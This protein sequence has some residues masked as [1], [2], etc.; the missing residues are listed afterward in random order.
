MKTSSV[1]LLLVT[2][3]LLVVPALAQDEMTDPGAKPAGGAR[4]KKNHQELIKLYDRNGDGRLDDEEKAAAHK[5][6]RKEGGGENDRRKQMLKRFDRD[7][8]GR[9]NDAERAEA[10]KARE[11]IEK[12]G[13][14]GKL[15]EQAIK[16]FDQDGDGRLN[17]TERAAAEKF[18]T[19][20]V[21]KFDADG[22]GQLNEAERE[23]ARQ[24]L[25]AGQPAGQRKKNQ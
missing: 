23:T 21:K 11:L 14:A 8:D 3:A 13:G 15:R 10:E 7:G 17:E 18:R 12:N 4:M 2:A 24:A 9:L 20:H 19:E 6:M 25:M 22:D 16:R 1:S 5:A